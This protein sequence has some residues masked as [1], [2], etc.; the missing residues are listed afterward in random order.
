MKNNFI[1]KSM[2]P[3]GPVFSLMLIGLLL[4]SA[5]LYYRAIK[6]QRFLEPA[7]AMSEPQIKFNQY[8]NHL[9]MTEFGTNTKW[10]TFKAGSILVNLSL[11]FADTHHIEESESLSLKKLSHVLHSALS[12]PDIREL[13]SLIL[14]STR[15]PLTTDTKLNKIL[16]FRSQERTARILNLLYAVEPELEKKYGTYFAATAM[17]VYAPVTEPNWVEFRMIPTKWLH[18]EVLER[19]GKYYY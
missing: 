6:I 15:F 11:L 3:T 12:D 2:M 14:V 9:L 4:L 8:I 1:N 13:I 18:I 17:P 19:L 10:I 16:R 7:L 5:L